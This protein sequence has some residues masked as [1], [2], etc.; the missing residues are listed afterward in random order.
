M[1]LDSTQQR[2]I[3]QPYLHDL[4]KCLSKYEYKYGRVWSSLNIRQ[5]QL[6]IRPTTPRTPI[7]RR[8]RE[9]VH[10]LPRFSLD[11]YCTCILYLYGVYYVCTS[12]TALPSTEYLYKY[13]V[14]TC[15]HNK[16]VHRPLSDWEIAG[17]GS[18]GIGRVPGGT[19][20][21]RR[22]GPSEQAATGQPAMKGAVSCRSG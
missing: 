17:F 13:R 9:F 22:T 19:N 20:H 6:I 4:Y 12:P 18:L 15:S 7:R 16:N 2:S 1:K 14:H 10:A 8:A 21:G 3:F 5:E 11:L